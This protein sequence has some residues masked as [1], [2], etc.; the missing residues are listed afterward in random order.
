M[1][2]RIIVCLV[3]SFLLLLWVQR[4][5]DTVHAKFLQTQKENEVKSALFR[6]PVSQKPSPSIK[7]MPCRRAPCRDSQ[8]VPISPREGTIA[9]KTTLRVS[10]DTQHNRSR[11]NSQ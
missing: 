2:T 4:R 8:V 10:A 11:G 9:G 7:K 6:A 3:L 5:T 1:S